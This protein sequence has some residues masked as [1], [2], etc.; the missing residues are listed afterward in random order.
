MLY[1]LTRLYAFIRR[2]FY[3]AQDEAQAHAAVL[4]A[5]SAVKEQA[6]VENVS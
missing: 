1:V 3:Q 4:A 5:A 2:D 6:R